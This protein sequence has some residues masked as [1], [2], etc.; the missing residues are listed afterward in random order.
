[1]KKFAGFLMLAA[2]AFTCSMAQA[3]VSDSVQ[4]VTP[5]T[6][7]LPTQITR[8]A[9][10]ATATANGADQTGY[11]VSRVV[12]AFNLTTATLDPSVTFSIQNKDATSG[13]Y[14]TLVTSA[15]ITSASAGTPVPLAAGAGVATTANVGAGVPLARTWRV[16]QTGGGTG[17]I[18]NTIGCSVQ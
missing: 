13:N 12:C 16:I 5:M 7:N 14:Y 10:I 9:A 8:S 18:T 15:A 11:N 3:Q 6:R 2:L 1:M 17:T 4:A